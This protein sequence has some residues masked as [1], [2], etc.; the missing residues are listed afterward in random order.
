MFA[1]FIIKQQKQSN[2]INIYLYSN[3]LI[4]IRIKI[5]KKICIKIFPLIIENSTKKKLVDLKTFLNK[6]IIYLDSK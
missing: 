3:K 6:I 5:L 2:L 4:I 1:H